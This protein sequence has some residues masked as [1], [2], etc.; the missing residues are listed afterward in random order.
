MWFR[1]F[2]VLLLAGLAG[3]VLA[4]GCFSPSTPAP[5][6]PSIESSPGSGP[7]AQPNEPPAVSEPTQTAVIVHFGVTERLILQVSFSG[8]VSQFAWLV[9]TPS[10]PAVSIGDGKVF[11]DFQRAT[12][13]SLGYWLGANEFNSQMARSVL[14]ARRDSVSVLERR[15][16]GDYDASVLKAN[17]GDDLL[18]WLRANKYQVREDMKPVLADYIGRGWVFTAVRIV[19]SA[20]EKSA[21]G[22]REGTLAP[23]QL[24]FS[25]DKPV[26]PLKVSSLNSGSTKVL[27][28]VVTNRVVADKTLPTECAIDGKSARWESVSSFVDKQ[29]GDLGEDV[30][31]E[32]Q[33]Y[34]VTKLSAELQP[35]Q[36]TEDIFFSRAKNQKAVEPPSVSPP[37]LA[38]IGAV[39]LMPVTLVTAVP[40]NFIAALICALAAY[41]SRKTRRAK[42]W[43]I[44]VAVLLIAW[45]PMSAAID[46]LDSQTIYEP[47]GLIFVLTSCFA[48]MVKL[49]RAKL[50]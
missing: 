17:S 46:G 9:P 31:A 20:Q 18:E 47:F 45:L 1:C 33:N 16:I 23:L 26:Y 29:A 15:V 30:Q 37:V 2:L 36:M 4:D 10:R 28:Y 11:K 12:A 24:E 13:P 14:S 43:M 5:D 38:N 34:Y 40:F 39:T 27:V 42:Y 48:A 25:S 8:N 6:A 22:L 50:L 21:E 32:E 35:E 7:A 19:D 41:A 44:A 3:P 49:R